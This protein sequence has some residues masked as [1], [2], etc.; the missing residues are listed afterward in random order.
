MDPR[1]LSGLLMTTA[2]VLFLLAGLI[3]RLT[4]PLWLV[5]GAVFTALGIA[6]LRRHAG[7]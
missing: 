7:S 5:L 2:G 3:L 1:Y 6:I 4:Q